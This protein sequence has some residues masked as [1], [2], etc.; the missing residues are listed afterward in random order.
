MK[1]LTAIIAFLVFTFTSFGHVK[2]GEKINLDQMNLS[3]IGNV[4]IDPTKFI[5]IDFWATWCA[6]CIAAFPHLESIQKKYAQEVQL[7][8][9]SDEPENKVATFLNNKNY[10]FDFYLDPE[11]KLFQLFD[12]VIRPTTCILNPEGVLIWVGNSAELDAVLTICTTRKD[13]DLTLPINP[14]YNFQKYYNTTTASD[15]SKFIY[16]YQLAISG[17]NDEYEAK[18][19]KGTYLDSAINIYYRAASVAEILQDLMSL[20]DLQFTNNRIELDTIMINLTAISSSTNI[21][22]KNE[23]DNIIN[24]LQ[25]VFSFDLKKEMKTVDTYFLTVK[26]P[27]KLKAYQESISGGGMVES[28]EEKYII[29]RL[30]L[31][32]LSSFLQ[33]KSRSFVSYNGSDIEKYTLEL[34]KFKTIEEL[35]QQLSDKFGLI[36]TKGQTSVMTVEIN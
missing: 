31:E 14:G 19:Q 22:Y 16:T 2:I 26:D 27:V 35:N 21:I 1:K 34:K 3:P 25:K 10:S 20:S 15:K 8:A 28:L 11:K 36:L 29:T 5:V 7:I 24:D 30:S 12:I 17:P 18:T 13:A 9:M 33:R 6:P 32:E 4:K 23:I